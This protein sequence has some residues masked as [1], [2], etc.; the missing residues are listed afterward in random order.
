MLS[1]KF[2]ERHEHFIEDYYEKIMEFQVTAE[3][4]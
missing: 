4:S 2:I 3:E 1:V